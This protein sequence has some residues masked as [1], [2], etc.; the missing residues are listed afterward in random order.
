MLAPH[1][2]LYR[3]MVHNEIN[4]HA[5]A[6]YRRK[7]T[8]VKTV[9][10]IETN[11]VKKYAIRYLNETSA[12]DATVPCSS[13]QKMRTSRNEGQA[14]TAIR[15][16]KETMS[17]GHTST[18]PVHE[19]LFMG[20]AQSLRTD[21][22]FIPIKEG[23]NGISVHIPPELIAY[24]CLQEDQILGV[25]RNKVRGTAYCRMVSSNIRCSYN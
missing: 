12:H 18:L 5:Y 15:I 10:I 1:K 16:S 7:A 4:E 2:Y 19:C 24:L 20:D 25:A 21:D 6:Y 22:L 23:D 14:S 11:G 8:E 17:L 3:K 13:L 9:D